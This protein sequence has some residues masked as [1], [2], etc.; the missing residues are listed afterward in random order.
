MIKNR[1]SD[2]RVSINLPARWVGLAGRHEARIEDLSLG[3]CFVNTKG[4]VDVGEVV[5]I[6]LKLPSGEWLQLRG[7]V[8]TYMVGT[9]FGVLFSFLTEDE[10][11]ALR[12]LI[13]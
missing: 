13:A 11:Q 9:G 12:E 10:E 2:E 3:G 7:E 6:E 4:R 5:G 1:R 8:A